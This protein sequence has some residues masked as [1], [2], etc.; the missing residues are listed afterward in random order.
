MSDW[1]RNWQGAVQRVLENVLKLPE[2]FPFAEPVPIDEVPG[3]RDLIST[4]M[5]LGTVLG[6]SKADNYDTP[7]EA[8]ADVR[9][10]TCTIGSSPRLAHMLMHISR[11]LCCCHVVLLCHWHSPTH[12]RCTALLKLCEKCCPT[13]T[14]PYKAWLHLTV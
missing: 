1:P 6:R 7:L 14:C 8:L 13:G 2:A 11:W 10:V 12:R 4:P 3:Y 9:Q 5:D